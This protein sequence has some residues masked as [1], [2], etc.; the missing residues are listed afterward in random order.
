MAIKTKK[1]TFGDDFKK[2]SL[3][4]FKDHMK[5]THG[6]EAKEAESVYKEIHGD[7][8]Q[9]E[10]SDEDIL[11]VNKKTGDV[12]NSGIRKKNNKSS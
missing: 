8:S 10:K 1:F 4:E 12:D 9:D 2:K 5:K 7:N 3:K 6:L 11:K